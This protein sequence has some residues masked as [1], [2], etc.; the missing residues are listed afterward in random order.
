MPL[1]ARPIP[2]LMYHQIDHAP[3]AGSALR[4]LV[5]AP[6]TFFLHMAAMRLLGY[7]G[8]SMSDLMPY[9]LGQKTGK[10]F[11][12]TFDDGYA[13]N[14]RHAAPV[15]KR[16]GFSSTCYVVPS[17]CG[18]TNQWDMGNGVAQVP[19][20][21]QQEMQAWVD[22]GQELG[23]HTLTHARLTDATQARKQAEIADSRR[24]IDALVPQPQGT[25][26]F[27]YPYGAFDAEVVAMVRQSGYATAT[28]TIRG[29]FAVGAQT[30]LFLVPR[31][32]VSRTTSWLHLLVKCLTRY[33]D[34]R[35]AVAHSVD[36]TYP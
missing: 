35:G 14:L 15:L 19:L 1:K 7:R 33:E 6:Q 23:S 8:L 10:V 28:T 20:M 22:A 27:C 12:I 13:N 26:H 2:V 31:V 11:G 25:C 36:G 24:A 21:N 16:F 4:G 29:R 32:L 9:L 3:P 5:V 34:K 17:L 30:D 18:K